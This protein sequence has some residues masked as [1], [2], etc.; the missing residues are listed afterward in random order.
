MSEYTNKLTS[1]VKAA[2]DQVEGLS[3]SISSVQDEIDELSSQIGAINNG[4]CKNTRDQLADYLENVKMPEI[5][6]DSTAQHRVYFGSTYGSIGYGTGNIE[7]WAIQALI[8]VIPPPPDPPI[9]VPTWVDVYVYEGVGWDD[10][11]QI[12][13]WIN[14]YSFGNDYLTR[15]VTSGATYGLQPN[16]SLLND[17]KAILERNKAKVD[18]SI[19]VLSR[20]GT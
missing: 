3:R 6:V 9:P 15:P 12:I 18:A 19:T 13:E 10:D 2:P 8:N 20:Y 17:G 1:M 11:A 16:K 4:V 14:D 5:S 7:D